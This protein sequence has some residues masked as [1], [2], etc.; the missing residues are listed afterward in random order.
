MIRLAKM[1]LAHRDNDALLKLQTGIVADLPEHDRFDAATL[2]L[3]MH[4][5]PD[6]EEGKIRL[7]R[8]IAQRLRKGVPLII[9]DI[10]EPDD[11]VLQMSYF[12]QYL[13]AKGMD[14]QMLEEGLQL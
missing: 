1:K 3:V 7:L 9:S 8:N 5:I 4:F 10:F 11:F 13:L 2:I 14:P 6:N 12:R